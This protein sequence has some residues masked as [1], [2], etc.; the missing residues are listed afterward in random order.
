MKEFFKSFFSFGI[1]T[2]T[3]KLLAFILLPIYARLFSTTEYGTIDLCQMILGVVTVFAVLQLETSLQRYYFHWDG[4]EKKRFL[5]TILIVVLSLSIIISILICLFANELS[6]VL[7]SYPNNSL[8]IILSALELPFIN[9]T[10]LGLLILRY[11]KKNLLFATQIFIKVVVLLMLT[12][13]FVVSMK[14]GIIWVFICQLLTLILSSIVLFFNI[15]KFLLFSFSFVYLKMSL[16]YALPQFPARMGSVLMIYSNRWFMIGFLS[17]AT[18]GLYSF[19]LKLASTVQ[20]L[21]TAFM[22]AWLPFMYEQFK[23]TNHR[24]I[25]SKVMPLV[26]GIL[27]LLVIIISLLSE[28]IVGIIA[29]NDF[30]ESYKYIGSLSLYFA[31]VIVKEVI[32]IGPKLTEKTIYISYNYF[33]SLLINVVSMYFFIKYWGV[34]GVVYSMLLTYMVLTIISWIVSNRLYYIPFSKRRFLSLATPAFFIS[35]YVMHFN[36]NFIVRYILLLLLSLGYG[37]VIFKD[38]KHLKKTIVLGKV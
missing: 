36:V 3:E 29:S 20:V 7:F 6:I 18:I 19:S 37:W 33:I 10:I 34:N 35:L 12:L 25:F 38:Y 13:I 9:F 26:S 2:T 27:F 31:L 16:K 30:K 8:L 32:D 4:D 1:A 14:G 28:D 23:N 11:E 22:M 24:K 15:R 17:T 5:S 21:G